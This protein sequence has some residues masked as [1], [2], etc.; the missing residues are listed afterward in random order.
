MLVGH[1]LG[2]SVSAAVAEKTP[3]LVEAL[4]L[5]DPPAFAHDD[6]EAI[7]LRFSETIETKRHIM[8]NRYEY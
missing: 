4:I 8:N 2:A 7:Q 6:F 5:E 1:S 3:D